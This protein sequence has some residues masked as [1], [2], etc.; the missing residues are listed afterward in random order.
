M[1]AQHD[2]V[3]RA[4]ANSL[5]MSTAPPKLLQ[6]FHL[7]CV[8]FQCIWAEDGKLFDGGNQVSLLEK[9]CPMLTYPDMDQWMCIED[10]NE[11]SETKD[12]N[13]MDVI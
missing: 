10:I 11:Q 1:V 8:A 5:T 9:H 13:L 4:P 6:P 7:Y 3:A 2:S 12:E